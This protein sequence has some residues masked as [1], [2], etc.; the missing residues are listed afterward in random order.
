MTTIIVGGHSRKVGKTAVT[1]ALIGAFAEYPWAAIKI[2][3]H[4]HGRLPSDNGCSIYEE[5]NRDGFTDSSRFLAA[6]AA[7][8]FWVRI[9]ENQIEAAMSQLL[10]ALQSSPFLIIESNNILQCIPKDILIMVLKYDVDDFKESARKILPKTNAI[11]AISRNASSPDWESV[12]QEIPAGIPV[13]DTPDPHVLPPGLMELVRFH[14][15]G[16][17]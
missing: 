13:F 14:L 11:V 16:Q 4:F 15:H 6:G 1:A 9:Q 3:T 10:P 8:S 17:S 7:R 2:S 5:H 12:M